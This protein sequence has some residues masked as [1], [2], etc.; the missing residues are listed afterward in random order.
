[1]DQLAEMR[2]FVRAVELGTFA[3]AAKELGL[4]PS[5]VSKLVTRLESRLAVRLINRTT[6][7]LAL[8]PEGETYF[9]SSQRIIAAI[10]ALENE[11]ANSA[12][13]PRGLLRVSCGITFGLRH[14]S[15]ALPD[16][17]SRYPEVAST[18]R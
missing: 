1:V 15:P 13:R 2:V 5:G 7:R 10:G 17:L 14:L 9:T 4:T 6:R 16:F 11:I 3:G 8:T 18:F 12:N